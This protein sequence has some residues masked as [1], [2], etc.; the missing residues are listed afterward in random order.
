MISCSYTAPHY[1]SRTHCH[2]REL[3]RVLI[4]PSPTP[5]SHSPPAPLRLQAVDFIVPPLLYC[6]VKHLSP[7]VKERTGCRYKFPE[8]REALASIEYRTRYYLCNGTSCIDIQVLKMY[9]HT[10][11]NDIHVIGNMNENCT[12]IVCSA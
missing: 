7:L 2:P 10:W 9:V 6:L 3:L 11:Q 8:M 1:R 5:P 4:T 12:Q